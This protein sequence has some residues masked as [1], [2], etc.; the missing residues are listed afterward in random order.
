MVEIAM[1]PQGIDW[2]INDVAVYGD[3]LFVAEVHNAPLALPD[4]GTIHVY[5]WKE[6]GDLATCPDQP[7]LLSPQ[8][9]LGSFASD[10]IPRQLV[11][12][13]ARN[14]LLVGATTKP[15]FVVK[16]GGLWFYDL[17]SFNPNDIAD[18]DNHRTDITADE[19]IRVTY[20]SVYD[21]LLDGDALYAVDSDNGLY[22]YSLSQET[23]VGF[24]PAH[25]G[26]TSQTYE[27]QLVL[28]PPG[29][30]P[31]HY[32]VAVALSPSGSLMVQEHVS[33]RVSILQAQGFQPEYSR[34]YL[35]LVVK[36]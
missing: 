34:V 28:S 26:T 13:S 15:T 9:P 8:Y 30:I 16:E 1:P 25:R 6:P 11:I 22:R 12:D 3:Y 23:Y 7:Q 24:Y 18:M 19:S 2:D 32:P 29:V 35:P 27:P 17:D 36:Q 14:R 4:S 33:G 5:R 10:L 31:L 20:S 21:I